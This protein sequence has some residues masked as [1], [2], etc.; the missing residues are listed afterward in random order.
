MKMARRLPVGRLFVS[1]VVW[2]AGL[3]AGRASGDDQIILPPITPA[4][5]VSVVAQTPMAYAEA[6]IPGR[7]LLTRTGSVLGDLT[8]SYQ[9]G[10]KAAAGQDYQALK[11]TRTIPAGQ[12]HVHITVHPLVVAGSGS[13]VKGVRVTL[14]SSD[15]Y[16]I[17]AEAKASVKIVQ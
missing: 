16:S 9:V 5:Q 17:S 3:S 7:F 2:A 1:A 8:V 12:T 4:T 15:G 13:T 14:L 6:G 11:G 10:G